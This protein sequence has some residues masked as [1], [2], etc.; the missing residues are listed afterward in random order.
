MVGRR[1]GGAGHAGGRPM[2]LAGDLGPSRAIVAAY[3]VSVF[4][5][6]PQLHK[7][8]GHV[9]TCVRRR[10]REARLTKS[11]GGGVHWLTA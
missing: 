11:G 2:G 4:K 7:H 8:L 10:G 6:K 9:P 5:E 1:F 3:A